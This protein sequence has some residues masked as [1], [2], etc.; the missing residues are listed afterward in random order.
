MLTCTYLL[1]V[2]SSCLW[3][4]RRGTFEWAC[5]ILMEAEMAWHMIWQPISSTWS[6]NQVS[7]IFLWHDVIG[8]LCSARNGYDKY[9][10]WSEAGEAW[11]R[12]REGGW[13]DEGWLGCACHSPRP[14]I[15]SFI[16]PLLHSSGTCNWKMLA[17]NA[18]L[19]TFW[20]LR[21]LLPSWYHCFVAITLNVGMKV[22][23]LS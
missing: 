5:I 9:A 1:F 19:A 12:E 8:M 15:T 16:I 11:E 22:C 7:S 10:S 17:Y 13:L 20:E 14:P 21:S 3:W 18:K 6:S 23:A 2:D 4:T